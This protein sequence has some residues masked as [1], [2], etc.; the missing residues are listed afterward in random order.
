M[1]TYDQDL[2]ALHIS[3]L[4]NVWHLSDYKHSKR[5]FKKTALTTFSMFMCG[6]TIFVW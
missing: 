6:Y 4:Y 3:I 5:I 1:K 2:N